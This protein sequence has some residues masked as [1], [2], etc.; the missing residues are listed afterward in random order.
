VTGNAYYL[1]YQNRRPDYLA[2]LV[3]HGRLSAAQ[4]GSRFQRLGG[5]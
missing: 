1:L 4:N 3:E 2:A 5:V